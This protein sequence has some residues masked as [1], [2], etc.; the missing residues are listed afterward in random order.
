M[1]T[2]LLDEYDYFLLGGDDLYV[3]VENLRRAL[4]SPELQRHSQN[5]TVPLYLGRVIQQNSYLQFQSGGAGYVLNAAAV[6][7]LYR[8]MFTPAC[9]PGISTSM[10]DLMVGHC[11]FQVTTLSSGFSSLSV[12]KAMFGKLI[13]LHFLNENIEQ[14]FCSRLNY[15]IFSSNCSHFCG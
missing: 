15:E 9:L 2:T 3:I 12:H 4:G 13:L 8:T 5:G 7:R 10:E 14:F 1:A 6:A 11:L